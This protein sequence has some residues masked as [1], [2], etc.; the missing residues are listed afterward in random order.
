MAPDDP[1]RTRLSADPARAVSRLT[2]RSLTP[3]VDVADQ[4]GATVGEVLEMAVDVGLGPL[5][6]SSV[7]DGTQRQ[8]LE[9]GW[10]AAHGGRDDARTSSE[11]DPSPGP[12]DLQPF[13]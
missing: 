13:D 6:R 3:L 11:S 4:L 1:D 2:T 10:A 7:L 8:R 5:H 9:R 12:P